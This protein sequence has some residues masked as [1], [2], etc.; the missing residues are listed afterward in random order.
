M[1]SPDEFKKFV[2]SVAL[3][4]DLKPKEIHLRKM[5]RKWASCS[6]RG[7][8]TFDTA[9]LKEPDEKI[10]EVVMHELMHLRYPHHGRMFNVMLKTY[11]SKN[12]NK[13]K[14]S[15]CYKK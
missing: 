1:M 6:S 7:R 14:N 15:K 8:L 4:A 3:E 9:L 11:L 10:A 2:Q 12:K 5:T 13:H